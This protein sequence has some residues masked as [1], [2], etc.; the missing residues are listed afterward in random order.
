MLGYQLQQVR[1]LLESLSM[2][3]V[4][5]NILTIEHSGER[6]HEILCL[7]LRAVAME[8]RPRQ[9]RGLV[10]ETGNSQPVT[11]TSHVNEE[12]KPAVAKLDVT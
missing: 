8:A 5:P 6:G 9:R 12:T 2:L 10:R 7:W 3:R 4:V 11:V 1:L